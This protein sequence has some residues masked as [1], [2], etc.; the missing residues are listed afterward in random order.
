MECNECMRIFSTIGEAFNS[1]IETRE[2][3]EQV[4]QV[5]VEQLNLKGCHFMLLS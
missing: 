5:V 1:P 4:A 3:L 2:L